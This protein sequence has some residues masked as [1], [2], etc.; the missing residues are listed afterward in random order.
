MCEYAPSG[1]LGTLCGFFP[2]N[3]V[4]NLVELAVDMEK[5]VEIS[6]RVVT[7]VVA[8]SI[9]SVSKVFA[10]SEDELDGE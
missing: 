3:G 5:R 8:L 2:K 6:V 7:E 10:D 4:A 1:V 9:G